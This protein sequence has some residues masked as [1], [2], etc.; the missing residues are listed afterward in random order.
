LKT[1]KT[2]NSQGNTEPKKKKNAGDNTIP[3]FKLYYKII[4]IKIA[5]Y[6]HKN[7]HE[8]QW[9]RTE[10]PDMNPHSYT[11]LIFV[12]DAQNLCW[13]KDSFFNKCYWEN[14]IS[15]FRKLK[16]DPVFHLIQVSAESGFRTLI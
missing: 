7:R 6:W 10:V 15:A 14:W 11:H 16:L 5:C 13:Q 3:N 2:L 1:Q 4:A 12:K 8:D 9:N